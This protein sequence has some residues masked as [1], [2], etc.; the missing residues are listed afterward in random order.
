M[1][2][3]FTDF[4]L[5]PF[6]PKH[7]WGKKGNPL[8]LSVFSEFIPA[9]DGW[10]CRRTTRKFSP[11]QTLDRQPFHAMVEWFQSAKANWRRTSFAG[12]DSKDFA[13]P[14]YGHLQ[15]VWQWHGWFHPGR[16]PR[17]LVRLLIVRKNSGFKQSFHLSVVIAFI[18]PMLLLIG[19]L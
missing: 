5:T 6:L 11:Y 14:H 3:H 9:Q 10:R 17:S 1:G 2:Q 15:K 16:H 13:S 7:C 18:I 19:W 4:Q 12:L 8:F